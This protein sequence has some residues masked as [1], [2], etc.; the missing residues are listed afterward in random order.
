[1]KKEELI[2]ILSVIPDNAEVLVDVGERYA[3]IK[4]VKLEHAIGSV[5]IKPYIII[6]IY[7]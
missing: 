7:E 3:E 6:D 2:R 5:E 1:M 4:D